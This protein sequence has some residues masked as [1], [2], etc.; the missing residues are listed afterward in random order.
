MVRAYAA[1]GPVTLDTSQEDLILACQRG[2]PGAYE[3]LFESYKDRAYS[4][5]F[6]FC[7][8]PAVASDITQDTFLKLLSRIG[9]FRGDSRF[10]TFLYRMVANACLDH[11]RKR[12]RWAP[13]LEGMLD[14]LVSPGQTALDHLLGA[15]F[16]GEVQ[17]SVAKLPAEQKL[18]VV[19]RYTE[20]LSYEEI[21]DILHCSPGTVASRLN[22]AHKTL[23]RRL[24][25]LK[26]DVS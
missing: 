6:R 13:I 16:A 4:V 25:H 11:Q 7:G 14:S 23:E 15:E 22:R 24:K 18:V 12:V 21:A 9:D 19:L 3:R 20:A 17:A 8:D 5:A 1:Q 26:K 2:V 10:E